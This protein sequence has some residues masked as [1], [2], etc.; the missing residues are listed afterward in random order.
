M[1]TVELIAFP[2]A[3]N[4]PIFAALEQGVSEK[5]GIALNMATAPRSP[6]RLPKSI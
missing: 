5:A 2:G 6:T 1:A 3:Q 4:P